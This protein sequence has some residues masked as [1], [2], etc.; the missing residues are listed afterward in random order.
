[1]KA[2]TIFLLTLCLCISCSST[3]EYDTN[4]SYPITDSECQEYYGF[5]FEIID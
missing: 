1:M 5:E 3:N 2:I 4:D